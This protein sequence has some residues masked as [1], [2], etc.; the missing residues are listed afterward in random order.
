MIDAAS[1]LLMNT[2]EYL[3]WLMD[4]Q[5]RGLLIVV[6]EGAFLEGLC[7]ALD[8]RT[9]ARATEVACRE[10]QRALYDNNLVSSPHI[11]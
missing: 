9:D 6:E 7:S 11:T 3:E 5:A 4:H 10:V 2:S 8:R 1:K